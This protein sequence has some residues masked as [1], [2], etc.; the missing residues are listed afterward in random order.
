MD[1]VYF[2]LSHPA[3]VSL[4]L[5]SYA[6]LR[7][8]VLGPED[9]LV[10]QVKSLL[11]MARSIPRPKSPGR[12]TAIGGVKPTRGN[13]N[14]NFQPQVQAVRSSPPD[15]FGT[16]ASVIAQQQQQQQKPSNFSNFSP[17]RS[18]TRSVGDSSPHFNRSIGIIDSEDIAS[19]TYRHYADS[20]TRQANKPLGRTL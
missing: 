19:S 8:S 7:K 13:G 17:P 18:G 16:R 1:L 6:Q 20:P 2:C 3:A 15:P 4:N 9:P 12:K 5:P 14:V 10:L 11:E